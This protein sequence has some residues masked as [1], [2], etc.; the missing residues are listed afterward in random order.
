MH[1]IHG[2]L[3]EKGPFRIGKWPSPFE[4][5][6]NGYKAQASLPPCQVQRLLDKSGKTFCDPITENTQRDIFLNPISNGCATVIPNGRCISAPSNINSITSY[7][8]KN[9]NNCNNYVG[10]KNYR[11]QDVSRKKKFDND[12]TV[13]AGVCVDWGHGWGWANQ[14]PTVAPQISFTTDTAI[15]S[16]VYCHSAEDYTMTGYDDVDWSA[17]GD[18]CF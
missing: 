4:S 7:S 11:Q 1:I 17:F 13:L 16:A 6:P 2:L 18:F 3:K 12:H 10:E 15:S 5:L 9:Y 14:T 8:S